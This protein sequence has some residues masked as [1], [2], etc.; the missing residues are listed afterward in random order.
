MLK[1]LTKRVYRQFSTLEA[2]EAIDFD[3]RAV[4]RDLSEDHR[5]LQMTRHHLDFS[6]ELHS[7]AQHEIK[8]R[9][10]LLEKIVNLVYIPKFNAKRFS[11]YFYAGE[12]P[13]TYSDYHTFQK[14][15]LKNIS[16]N[17]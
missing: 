10:P 15:N 5:N 7:L 3:E 12:N 6:M 16:Q 9:R 4:P 14:Q 13:N 2:S 8:I 17:D 1:T 11:P